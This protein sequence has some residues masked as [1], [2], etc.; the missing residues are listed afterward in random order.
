MTDWGDITKA[1]EQ[2]P[3]I[4]RRHGL[5]LVTDVARAVDER[6]PFLS[7]ELHSDDLR[8]MLARYVPIA[9]GAEWI[10]ALVGLLDVEVGELPHPDT[11]P[12]MVDELVAHRGAL[13][14]LPV[15]DDDRR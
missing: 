9:E 12:E 8:L 13:D 11:W 1:S 4:G 3:P 5:Q 15:L 10:E 7:V 14:D 6:G 2:F